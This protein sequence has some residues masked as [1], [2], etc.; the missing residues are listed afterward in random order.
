MGTSQRL[1][2]ASPYLIHRVPELM[3][4]QSSLWNLSTSTDSFNSSEN[5][6]WPPR[7]EHLAVC[8]ALESCWGIQLP[9]ENLQIHPKPFVDNQL[10][11][12]H[13]RKYSC[14]DYRASNKYICIYQ[15]SKY[16]PSF[17]PM[18]CTGRY[19]SH[20]YS[21]LEKGYLQ[22][23]YFFVYLSFAI[24]FTKIKPPWD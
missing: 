19:N 21:L 11:I 1:G 4:T 9:N 12:Q 16:S 2:T 7:Y 14:R 3:Q 22:L 20:F 8:L 15:L 24:L 10:C 17:Y 6:K 18:S 13:W 5:N 23:S